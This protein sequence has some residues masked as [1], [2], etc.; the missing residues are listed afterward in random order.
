MDHVSTLRL[1]STVVFSFLPQRRLKRQ[2][3]PHLSAR[4][5]HLFRPSTC[6]GVQ[7]SGHC[8]QPHPSRTHIYPHNERTEGPAR[9][10]SALYIFHYHTFST[11][12]FLGCAGCRTIQFNTPLRFS[13]APIAAVP[14]PAYI[15]PP[16]RNPP[17]RDTAYKRTPDINL[18][19]R[20]ETPFRCTHSVRANC[21]STT[22]TQI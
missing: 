1:M 3:T 18:Q 9:R 21:T 12:F 4:H 15:Y 17:Q 11:F 20:D 19:R 16:H 2:V 6:Q 8:N 5:C 14:T 10:T 7:T 22:S 13:P